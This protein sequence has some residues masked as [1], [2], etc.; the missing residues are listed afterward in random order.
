MSSRGRSRSRPGAGRTSR[1][2]ADP[3]RAPRTSRA[4]ATPACA[5]RPHPCARG[6]RARAASSPPACSHVCCLGTVDIMALDAGLL[7][8]AKAAEARVIDAEHDVEV[9]RA[10]F[11][12]MVRR[13]QLAGASLRE[14]AEALGLSH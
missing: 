10:D 5:G 11:H 1:P 13:L 3:A 9:A 8:Q 4:T 6:G 14:I 2:R 12:R 7:E